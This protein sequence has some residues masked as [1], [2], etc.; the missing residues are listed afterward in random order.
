M[1]MQSHFGRKTAFS[2]ISSSNS[3]SLYE[4]LPFDG[5]SASRKMDLR[6]PRGTGTRK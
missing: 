1:S 3:G 5:L 6:K 4:P 2:E